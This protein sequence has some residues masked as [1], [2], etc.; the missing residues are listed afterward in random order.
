MFYY[1]N[2]PLKRDTQMD[3]EKWVPFVTFKSREGGRYRKRSSAPTACGGFSDIWQCDGHFSNAHGESRSHPQG[4]LPN[5]DSIDARFPV[6]AVVA[7]KTLRAVRLPSGLDNA[8]IA[9]RLLKRLGPELQIWMRLEHPNVVPLVGFTITE[10]IALV[11]PWFERGNVSKYLEAH[12]D[13]NRMRLTQGFAAGL[14][15]LHSSTPVIVHGDIKPDNILVD[16]YGHARIIDFGLSKLVEEE[17]GLSALNSSSL[18][19][20]GNARWV[21]PE[22]ILEENASRSRLTDIYS[23]GCVLFFV[24]HYLSVL[25]TVAAHR[26][27]FA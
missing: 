3:G 23:F 24:S 25:D 14:A 13:A 21:A 6:G 11:S 26:N 12:P 18:R 8:Q 9:K 19:D 2:I 17:P 16:K 15:Y 5:P 20:A 1:E 4:G 27:F 10:E 7:V 22:L